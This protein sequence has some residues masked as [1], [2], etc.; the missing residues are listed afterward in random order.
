MSGWEVF[1]WVNVAILGVGSVAVFVAFVISLPDL[2]RRPAAP[3]DPVAR[4]SP[5]GEREDQ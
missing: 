3:V 5:A 1:T 2:L 4:D